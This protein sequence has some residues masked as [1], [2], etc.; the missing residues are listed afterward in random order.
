[1]NEVWLVCC[2]AKRLTLS[3]RLLATLALAPAAALSRRT[4]QSRAVD[5]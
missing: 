5:R 2:A 1:M 4:A 3:A